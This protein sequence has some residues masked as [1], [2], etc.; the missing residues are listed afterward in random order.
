MS[1]RV[2]EGSQHPVLLRAVKA[3]AACWVWDK[4]QESQRVIFQSK[5]RPQTKE[6][7]MITAHHIRSPIQAELGHEERSG[8]SNRDAPTVRWPSAV[9]RV[10]L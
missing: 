3:L 5:A 8:Y 1:G 10:E 6:D 4:T 7:L 2:R 9:G